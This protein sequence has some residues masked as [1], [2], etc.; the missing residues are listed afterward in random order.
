[1]IDVSKILAE[2]LAEKLNNN[3][4][5]LPTNIDFKTDENKTLQE[6]LYIYINNPHLNMQCDEACFEGWIV[7]FIHHLNIQN[8]VLDWNSD[9]KVEKDGH[10]NRFLFRVYKFQKMFKENFDIEGS[11]KEEV[12][13]FI[14]YLKEGK[15]LLNE[16]TKEATNNDIDKNMERIIEGKFINEYKQLLMKKSNCGEIYSQLPVGVFKEKISK[17][18]SIFT[19][20]SSAIDLWGVS[21]DRKDL[22]VFELKYDNTKMGIV[23]ELLFYMYVLDELCVTKNGLF[24]YLNTIKSFRGV[25]N[26][27]NNKK[28]DSLKGYFLTDRLH[29]IITKGYINE[30]NKG[31]KI[32]GKL[33]IEDIYYKYEENKIE[34]INKTYLQ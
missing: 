24:N 3:K 26:F 9:D 13:N 34:L 23:S 1:M 20:G 5:M 2:K 15:N 32:L 18:K 30:L 11:K 25:E 12:K 21:E 7:A 33:E 4:I 31:L 6:E 10:Y 16:P 22:S 17:D 8:I 14:E 19:G 29:P 27:K 28:Y